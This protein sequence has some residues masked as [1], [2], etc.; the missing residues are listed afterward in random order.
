MIEKGRYLKKA[1]DERY[2]SFCPYVIET[3]KTIYFI[4]QI[5]SLARHTFISEVEKVIRRFRNCDDT[6]KFKILLSNDAV[7]PI[8]GSYLYKSLH[9]RNFSSQKPKNLE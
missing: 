1:K 9:A 7:L 3:V 2:Y 5:I 4:L 8:T 6:T